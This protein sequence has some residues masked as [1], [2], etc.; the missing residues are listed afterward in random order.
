[1]P[2]YYRSI[3]RLD[4]KRERMIKTVENGAEGLKNDRSLF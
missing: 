3:F 1:M 2:K 4:R